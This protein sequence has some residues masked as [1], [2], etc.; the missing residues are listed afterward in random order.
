MTSPLEQSFKKRLQ[1]IAKE[2]NLAP[3]EVWQNVISERFLVRLC[4]SDYS[5]HFILKGGTLLAKNLKIGRETNDLDFLIER[6]SNEIKILQNV[7]EEIARI[8]ME[9]GFTFTNLNVTPLEHFHMQ[10]P[11]AQVRIE[12][13]YGK[14]KFPLFI[15]IGFGDV[16][17]AQEQELL[18]LSYS[19]GPLFES[20]IKMKCYPMEYVFAEKLETAIYRGADNSRMKDFHDLYTLVSTKDVLHGE[21]AEKALKAVFSHRKT[22]MH[23]PIEF[24]PDAIE[25]LQGYWGRYRLTAT[26][27]NLLP[28][29]IEQV[30]ERINSWITSHIKI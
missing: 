26:A 30:I 9:D 1:V 27:P 19:K 10:Y 21:E 14:S 11:G 16:V 25:S 3:S 23:L 15:D 22:P 8:D 13:R 20:F 24:S 6:I 17:R 28:I 2:R 29:Q 7:F 5:S 12:V 4:H 18:L